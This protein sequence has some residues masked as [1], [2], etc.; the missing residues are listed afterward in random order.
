VPTETTL[1]PLPP[2]P[3]GVPAADR[4]GHKVLRRSRRQRVVAGVAGGIAEY[5]AID[6]AIVRIVIVVATLTTG[7]PILL[8]PLAVFVIP[9]AES[10]Q[11]NV[12]TGVVTGGTGGG[13]TAASMSKRT[14]LGPIVLVAVGMMLMFDRIGLHLR[15]DLLWPLAFIGIGAA[16][17]WSRRGTHDTETV[18]VPAGHASFDTAEP[19]VD[20][21]FVS[22]VDSPIV[23]RAYDRAVTVAPST[24]PKPVA[25]RHRS[26]YARSGFAIFALTSGIAALAIRVVHI[27]TS[28]HRLLAYALFWLGVLLVIGAF[29]GRPR[30]GL[31]G[32]VLALSLAA[33]SSIRIDVRGGVGER[34]YVPTATTL[35]PAYRLGVGSMRLDLRNISVGKDAAVLAKVGIGEL[36][37]TVPDDVNITAIVDARVGSAQIFEQGFDGTVHERVTS[38]GKEGASNLTLD[39]RVSVGEVVVRR[40][41][42]SEARADVSTG[43]T[44]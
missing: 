28:T 44:T 19:T 35:A 38:P 37:V 8:Y 16:V 25:R 32:A 20:H 29:L 15:G 18:T 40:A 26:L 10:E 9:K 2:G 27:D 22:L 1:P 34:I 24:P 13:E 36:V 23:Q 7:I 6:V 17:L 14:S 21:P 5:F 39:L 12:V 30:L 11:I 43:A 4:P 3:V 33:A 42:S 41:S 31:L